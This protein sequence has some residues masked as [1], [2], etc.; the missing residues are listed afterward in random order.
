F[1]G[2]ERVARCICFYPD[3]KKLVSG[4]SDNTLRIIWDRR[5]GAVEELRG[6]TDTV[7]DVD[8]S[9]D[10]RMFVSGSADKTVRIW[11]RE[12]GEIFEGHKSCV[13]S[14]QFSADSSRVVSGSWD[15]TVRIWSIETGK[16]VFEPIKCHGMVWCVRYSPSGDR[17]ASGADNIQIWNAETGVGIL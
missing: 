12:S 4:W 10:G 16:L 11:N 1:E 17:I 15:G 7:W 5:V 2:H 3:E 13:R 9:R 14:V 6:H 8:V